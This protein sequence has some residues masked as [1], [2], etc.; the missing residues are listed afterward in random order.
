MAKDEYRY[1]G[2]FKYDNMTVNVYSPI[3][4]DEENKRRKQR[5]YDATAELLKEQMLHSKNKPESPK[6]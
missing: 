6:K 3:I 2:T 4:S 1:A 5:I